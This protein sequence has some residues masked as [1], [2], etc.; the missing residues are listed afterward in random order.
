[1][2]VVYS[3]SSSECGGTSKTGKF[4]Q[5]TIILV[6]CMYLYLFGH[7]MNVM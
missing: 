6:V 2:V 3:L 4:I 1:M 5:K 7:D